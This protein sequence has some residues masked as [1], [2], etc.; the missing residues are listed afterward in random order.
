MKQRG[1]AR[2][3]IIVFAILEGILLAAFVAYMVFWK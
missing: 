2:T 1:S 3:P